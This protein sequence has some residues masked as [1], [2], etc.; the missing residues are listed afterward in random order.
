MGRLIELFE[1][2]DAVEVSIFSVIFFRAI[3][4]SAYEMRPGLFRRETQNEI[5]RLS[6][7]Y[8]VSDTAASRE[9][10]PT[11]EADDRLADVIGRDPDLVQAGRELAAIAFC[12]SPLDILYCVHLTLMQIRKSVGKKTRRQC[13]RST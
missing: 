8:R 1:L 3:F 12:N 7:S 11:C 13:C 2:K 10:M 4:D 9:F 6:R 5:R